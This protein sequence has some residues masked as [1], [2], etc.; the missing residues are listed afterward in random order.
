[1]NDKDALKMLWEMILNEDLISNEKLLKYGNL[2]TQALLMALV[3]GLF[4]WNMQLT[5]LRP[6]E[7]V[8]ASRDLNSRFPQ[9]V[10]IYDV[11]ISR[12]DLIIITAI[13][14][15]CPQVN[16]KAYYWHGWIKPPGRDPSIAINLERM[17]KIPLIGGCY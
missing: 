4:S 16:V 1:M 3:I 5:T 10:L 12:E 13:T 9:G 15:G 17:E 7:T 8:K 2:A 6:I 14:E 11:K